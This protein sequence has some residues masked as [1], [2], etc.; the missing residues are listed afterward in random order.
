MPKMTKAQARRRLTEAGDKLAK[1]WMS[2]GRAT[3]GLSTQDLNKLIAIR[4]QL[5][6][7]AKNLK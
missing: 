6:N 3:V 5:Q 7:M 1:V 2:S 4:T